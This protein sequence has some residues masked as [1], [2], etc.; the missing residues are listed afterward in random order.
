[1]KLTTVIELIA[2]LQKQDPN[3]IVIM[4]SD[5][6]GNDHSPLASINSDMVYTPIAKD[7]W[8]SG[9]VDRV[10]EEDVP[11]PN[12]KCIVLRPLR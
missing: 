8:W 4:S 12:V 1:M 9:E 2:F 5:S 7:K 6:E 10:G 11:G 3:D